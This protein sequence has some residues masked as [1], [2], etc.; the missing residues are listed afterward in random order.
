MSHNRAK[1]CAATNTG[2]DTSRPNQ[3][4]D[5]AAATRETGRSFYN[6]VEPTQEALETELKSC[7]TGGTLPKKKTKLKGILA[8]MVRVADRIELTSRELG[9]TF[10]AA[11]PTEKDL[12]SQRFNAGTFATTVL[13]LHRHLVTYRA[14]DQSGAVASSR[15]GT[16]SL[17]SVVAVLDG[18]YDE[19]RSNAVDAANDA[20]NSAAGKMSEAEKNRKY[21]DRGT[22]PHE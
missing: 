22:V 20:Q 19:A 10:R 9:Q 5:P 8:D 12:M 4:A 11:I 18:F 2:D 21:L 14:S 1:R 13:T 3:R 15:L 6:P 7:K 16:E 17:E